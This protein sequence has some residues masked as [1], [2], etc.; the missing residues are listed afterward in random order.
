LILQIENGEQKREINNK[1][2]K[3]KSLK[4]NKIFFR[5]LWLAGWCFWSEKRSLRVF[6]FIIII[7]IIRLGIKEEMT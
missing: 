5:F 2:K 7:I 3:K 6:F 1:K 4:R